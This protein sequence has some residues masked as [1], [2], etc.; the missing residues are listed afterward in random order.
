MSTVELHYWNIRGLGEPIRMM[1][2]YLGVE[3]EN[4]YKL[5]FEDWFKE[6]NQ[7]GI[8][9]HNLPT[10]VDGEV[11]LTQSF[12]IMRYLARKHKQL[13]PQDELQTRQVDQAEGL[14]ADL[15]FAFAMLA[16]N[17]DFEKMKDGFLKELPA[18]L[19]GLEQV[20]AKRG[21]MATQLTHV[22]FCLAEVLDHIE[23]CYPGCYDDQM[24]SIKAYK[25]RF[26]ALDKIKSYKMSGRWKKLP[27][28]SPIA[29]WGGKAE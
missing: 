23:M 3:Y 26:D 21:W 8:E 14:V 18:K 20:L 5:S 28:Y 15:R 12:A 29:A 24:P 7:V 2:E 19:A 27:V 10:L 11:K 4:K 25:E 16:Y 22:D 13:L 9:L 17:P 1:L 6:K